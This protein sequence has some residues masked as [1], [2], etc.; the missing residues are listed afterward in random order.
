MNLVSFIGGELMTMW[1]PISPYN[2][3]SCS[4]RPP[5]PSGRDPTH[6]TELP[7]DTVSALVS[8]LW[9]PSGTSGG[10]LN[11]TSVAPC[12]TSF[13]MSARDPRQTHFT[14]RNQCASV[15]QK[16]VSCL[17]WRG[18]G[19]LNTTGSHAIPLVDSSPGELQRISSCSP[20]KPCCARRTPETPQPSDG[21]VTMRISPCPPI[22]PLMT[23]F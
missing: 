16:S 5:F 9:T 13:R 7:I 10:T 4:N 11:K 22:A 19:D 6:P 20:P 1:H 21:T 23:S 18:E 8:P 17:K 14:R 2:G 12:R 15:R 3:V